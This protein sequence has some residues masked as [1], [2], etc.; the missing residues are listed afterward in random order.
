MV[1]AKHPPQE[2]SS[3]SRLSPS[4]RAAAAC[5]IL[6]ATSWFSRHQLL[7]VTLAQDQETAVAQRHDVGIAPPGRPHE[8]EL[9]EE[10]SRLQLHRLRRYADFEGARRDEIHLVAA[11]APGHHHLT[12][13]HQAR[14][15]PA[16]EPALLPGVEVLEQGHRR[17]Q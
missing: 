4:L 11:L 5:S 9:A 17:D 1:S 7:D 2:A 13:R 10:V 14:A 15:Q 3:P 12:R 6:A 8:G 16:F